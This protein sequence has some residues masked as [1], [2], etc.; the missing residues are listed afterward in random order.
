M[1]GITYGER[2]QAE[3]AVE[4]VVEQLIA[5]LR[6]VRPGHEG[7]VTI[8]GH[9]FEYGPSPDDE[10]YAAG[11]VTAVHFFR[12]DEHAKKVLV[13]L[14][15]KALKQPRLPPGSRETPFVVAYDN[16]EGEL[17]ATT[18]LS[19]LTGSRC[20]FSESRPGEREHWKR[21]NPVAHPPHVMAALA[22]PWGELLDGWDFGLDADVRIRE[23]GA[24]IEATWAANLSGVLFTHV[25][26]WVQ[27]FPN[28]F[29]RPELRELRL[30]ELGLPLGGLEPHH[31]A[32]HR[33][34]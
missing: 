19:A 28:P 23:Y 10:G 32:W 1:P 25:L 9:R 16:R 31:P 30:L 15:R 17:S 22:G 27:W 21:T 5:H 18:V 11:G 13:E 20:A 6:T 33:Y 14:E 24:L 4:R 2:A 3:E 29:A 26:D 8:D 12:E 34:P 7:S